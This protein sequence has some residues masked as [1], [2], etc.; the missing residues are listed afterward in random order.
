MLEKAIAQDLSLNQIKERIAELLS[1]DA[2]SA[3]PLEY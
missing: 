1:I 2:N 3:I